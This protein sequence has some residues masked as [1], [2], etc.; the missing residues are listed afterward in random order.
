MYSIFGS[1]AMTVHGNVKDSGIRFGV[2]NSARNENLFK[3]TPRFEY[4]T[5]Q[6]LPPTPFQRAETRF[7]DSRKSEARRQI[8]TDPKARRDVGSQNVLAMLAGNRRVTFANPLGGLDERT[9]RVKKNG[10]DCHADERLRKL[11]PIATKLALFIIE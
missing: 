2:A 6:L 4:P 10:F 7:S 5:N 3:G 8:E 9:R 1:E 11:N